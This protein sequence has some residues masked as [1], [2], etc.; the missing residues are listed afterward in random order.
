MTRTIAVLVLAVS[1]TTVYVCLSS[2]YSVRTTSGASPVG[3][4][5][6]ALQDQPRTLRAARRSCMSSFLNYAEMRVFAFFRALSFGPLGDLA[7]NGADIRDDRLTRCEE[8]DQY[9]CRDKENEQYNT[10]RKTGVDSC[11]RCFLLLMRG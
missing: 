2:R 5:G 8:H 11:G 7:I 9:H 1:S 6:P 3:A 10:T 4:V